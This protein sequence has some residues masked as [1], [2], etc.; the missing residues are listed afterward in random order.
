MVIQKEVLSYHLIQHVIGIFCLGIIFFL[1]QAGKD[2]E[3]DFGNL[4]NLDDLDEYGDYDQLQEE[5][6]GGHSDQLEASQDGQEG[7]SAADF[8]DYN[9][10]GR[11]AAT[12]NIP[13][14]PKYLIF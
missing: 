9:Q 5:G 13:T 8:G 11:L 14:K 4:D 2:G 7:N 12:R 3:E 10:E 1:L 6:E